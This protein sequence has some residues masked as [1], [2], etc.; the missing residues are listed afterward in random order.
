[1]PHLKAHTGIHWYYTVEGEG[2]CL[3]FIHG[4]G[5]DGRIWRQQSKYFSNRYKVITLDMPGHGESSF[6]KISLEAMAGDIVM[7]LEH[8]RVDRLT[9]VGSSFGGMMALRLYEKIPEDVRRIIF[10]GSMPK[11]TKSDDYPYGLDLDRIRKLSGQ[12][13]TSYPSIINIFF[14][15]LF[16]VEERKSRRFKWLQKFRQTDQVPIKQALVEYLDILEHED[17]REILRKIHIPLQFI[18]GTEDPI[19]DRATVGF[20]RQLKPASHFVDFDRCGHFPF[21]SKPHEFN[22]VVEDFLNENI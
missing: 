9:V 1:M 3:L 20:I 19:C 6:Q 13:E 2:E 8:C 10:V 5:V 4:W 16:T 15:S 17:V 12:L 11:F 18:N 21:L 22:K 7:I 14:R